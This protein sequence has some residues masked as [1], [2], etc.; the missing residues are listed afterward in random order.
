MANIEIDVYGECPVGEVLRLLEAH[1]A[2]I[3][4]F[5]F[6]GPRGNPV[7]SLEL[8]T[9]NLES[10]TQAW[11]DSDATVFSGVLGDPKKEG[12][13]E[14]PKEP[15]QHPSDLPEPEE[16]DDNRVNPVDPADPEGEEATRAA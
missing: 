11:H 1:G 13:K 12:E 10:F 3:T 9:E 4:D 8:P 2:R 14:E 6:E 16:G 5:K 15:T 7:L